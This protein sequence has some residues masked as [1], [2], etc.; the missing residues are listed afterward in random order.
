[1]K[2]RLHWLRYSLFFLLSVSLFTLNSRAQ[3]AADQTAEQVLPQFNIVPFDED[4]SFFARFPKQT[5]LL[6]RMKYIPFGHRTDGYLSIGGEFRG[7]YER[8]LND[9]WSN[10]PVATNSFGLQRYLLHTD[11]HVSPH[12]RIFLELESGVEQGRSAGPRPIDEKHPDF[13][14]AF[15]DVRPWGKAHALT[16]RIG[17]QELQLGSGRSLSV[18]EGLNVRQAFYGIRADQ[19]IANWDFTGFA[20]RPAIDRPGFFNGGPLGSTSLWGVLGNRKWKRNE[21][22]SANV[23]Y[24]GLDRK[25]ATYNRGTAREARQTIGVNFVVNPPNAAEPPA[26]LHLKV[27]AMYQFGTFGGQAIRAWTIATE[28]GVSL[29]RLPSTPRL[30]LRADI[31][32]GD[33]GGRSALGTFNPLFPAGDYFGVLAGT[34]PGPV[35]F[36]DLHPKVVLSLPHAITLAPDWIFWWRQQLEDGVYSVP[37]MLIVPAGRST[38]RYVGH[39]PGME[40]RWQMDRHAYMQLSYGVFF[41]GPFLKQSGHSQNLDYFAY[42]F[43]YKF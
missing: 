13:L 25:S 29:S 18:R 8:V 22:F 1:M 2:A 23:Y 42:G 36:R 11:I 7:T 3:V 39:R 9:N 16:L 6:E 28:T 5:S 24:Y 10:K 15:V 40:A 38:A 35:N 21:S 27:E 17:K 41:A 33:K 26:G 4:W 19:R 34:G 43:G 12:A 37:G 14:N 31:S 32:S 20:V 30:E